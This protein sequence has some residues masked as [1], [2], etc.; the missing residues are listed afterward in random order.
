MTPHP[1]S[2]PT[3][4]SP[5]PLPK[6]DLGKGRTIRKVMGGGEG[7]F[8]AAGIFFSLSN[9]L[10]EFFLGHSM[11]IFS[12]LIGVHEFFSFNFPLREYFFLYFAPPPPHPPHKFSNGPPLSLIQISSQGHSVAEI[13]NR[14]NGGSDLQR[15]IALNQRQKKEM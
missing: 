11:N 5:A 13:K 14:K 9:S 2:Q 12:G 8:R 10:H 3:C 7:N 1:P 15:I 4:P 6:K